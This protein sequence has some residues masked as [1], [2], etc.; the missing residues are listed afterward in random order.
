MPY[1]ASELS[2]PRHD[3]GV[4]LKQTRS[5][6]GSRHSRWHQKT[7]GIFEKAMTT[8]V[9]NRSIAMRHLYSFGFQSNVDDDEEEEEGAGNQYSM[10]LSLS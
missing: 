2:H 5:S 3:V 4:Q 1:D 6:I 8:M 7:N 9:S 10:E